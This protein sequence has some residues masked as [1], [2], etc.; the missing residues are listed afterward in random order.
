M[1]NNRTSG[2]APAWSGALACMLRLLYTGWS[3]LRTQ[4]NKA[5][6]TSLVAICGAVIMLG[7]NVILSHEGDKAA[8]YRVLDA[9]DAAISARNLNAYAHLIAD[10]YQDRGWNKEQILTRSRDMFSAFIELDMRSF[11]RDLRLLDATHAQCRQ[12]YRL[13]ARAG[14]DWRQIVQREQISLKKTDAGWKIS[15]G[16]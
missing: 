14:R 5:P 4:Y 10:D 6:L 7:L 12:T 3:W 13:K 16:L 15:G 11:D 8:I 2:S 9:R 1:S